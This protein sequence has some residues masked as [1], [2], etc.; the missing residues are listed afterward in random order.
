MR[1]RLV[2]V[3]KS[4]TKRDTTGT[5]KILK[6][7]KGSKRREVKR[8]AG[9]P[10]SQTEESETTRMVISPRFSVDVA[11]ISV[12][13]VLRALLWLSVSPVQSRVGF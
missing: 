7:G 6:L 5:E 2:E 4:K 3:E 1:Q 10:S 13:L 8:R 11:S 9:L 12:A